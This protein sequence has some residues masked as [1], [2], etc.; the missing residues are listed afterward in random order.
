[1]ICERIRPDDDIIKVDMADFANVLTKSSGH[2]AL[3]SAG[4]IAPTLRHNS[5]FVETKRGGS[6]SILNVVGVN[7]SLEEG[8][9][10]VKFTPDTA[11]SAIGK[12]IIDAWQ[13][14]AI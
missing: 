12:D 3:M 13:R 4:S 11:T 6:S 2:T 5:P 7:A 9:S 1:M 8:V 14:G 10:H